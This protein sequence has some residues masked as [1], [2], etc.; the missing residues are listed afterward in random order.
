M[1]DERRD[2]LQAGNPIL[3]TQ[4]CPRANTDVGGMRPD[5][6]GNPKLDTGRP[7]GELVSQFFNTAAFASYCP[8]PDGPFNFGNAGRNIVIGPGVNVWD[9]GLYKEFRLKGEHKRLQFRSEF[10]NLFNHPIFGQPGGT[11]GTPQFGVIGG[12]ALDPREI[13]FALKGVERSQNEKARLDKHSGTLS[14]YF[15]LHAWAG[16]G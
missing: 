8:G 2:D 11:A 16:D 15:F 6:V 7:S 4:A 14:I 10:F 5:V 12:T 13:Q 3:I 1:V 9:F